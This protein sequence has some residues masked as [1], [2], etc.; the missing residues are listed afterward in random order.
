MGNSQSQTF[1][2]SSMQSKILIGVAGPT[3]SGKT[4]LSKFLEEK[5]G[6]RALV[7][8]QDSFYI[9]GNENTNFDDPKQIEWSLLTKTLRSLMKNKIT[10]VPQY[11]FTTHDRKKETIKIN[12]NEKDII[13]VEGILIYSCFELVDMINVK[14]FVNTKPDLCFKRR[15]IRDTKERGRTEE[16]VIKR[17]NDHVQPSNEKYVY[18]SKEKAD[19]VINNN[20][21]INAN[22]EIPALNEALDYL[23][24][25]LNSSAEEKKNGTEINHQTNY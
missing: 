22:T 12:P 24:E 1:V 21:K 25:Y 14:Y 2:Q 6:K 9:P 15:L 18:P 19:C 13:I 16:E 8:S 23:N 10:E 11:D 4:L 7:I 17:Y 3:C 5:L 20:E